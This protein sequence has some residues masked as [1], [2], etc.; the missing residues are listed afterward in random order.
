MEIHARFGDDGNVTT[1]GTLRNCSLMMDWS[2]SEVM[3][4]EKAASP[5]QSQGKLEVEIGSVSIQ[6]TSQAVMKGG[7]LVLQI[8]R[9]SLEISQLSVKSIDSNLNQFVELMASSFSPDL[10]KLLNDSVCR[11][12]T[13]VTVVVQNMIASSHLKQSYSKFGANVTIDA[14]FLSMHMSKGAFHTLHKGDVCFNGKCLPVTDAEFSHEPPSDGITVDIKKEVLDNA[15]IL[16]KET[17]LLDFELTFRTIIEKKITWLNMT[18]WNTLCIENFFPDIASRWPGRVVGVR[19]RVGNIRLSMS[20]VSIVVHV[21]GRVYFS[22][23]NATDETNMFSVDCRLEVPFL[24]QFRKNTLSLK[25]AG[26]GGSFVIDQSFVGQILDKQLQEYINDTVIEQELLP[27][28]HEQIE[29]HVISYH[30]PVAKDIGIDSAK[31]IIFDDMIRLQADLCDPFGSSC[32]ASLTD[33][34]VGNIQIPRL[35]IDDVIPTTQAPKSTTKNPTSSGQVAPFT[36]ALWI[37]CL[38]SILMCKRVD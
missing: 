11:N 37:I 38:F 1:H 19:M 21:N 26:I 8:G 33:E 9:C 4:I 29:K 18:C 17:Q 16:L 28:I 32:G 23:D 14:S 7:S 24:M 2:M 12:L 34:W 25:A 22:A 20:R 27:R 30:V 10:K 31:I 35:Q 13:E 36:L 3:V 15:I 6:Y 5:I